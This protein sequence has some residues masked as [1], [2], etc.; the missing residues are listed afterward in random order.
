MDFSNMNETDVREEIVRPLLHDLGYR[1]NAPANI[2]TEVPLRYDYAF[3]GRK[4]ASDP[5]L[6]G[7]ADYICEAT[8]YGRWTVEVK[9]PSEDITRDAIEQ[10]HTYSAHPEIA[11]SY[12]LL[13]NGKEFELYATGQLE[14]PVL[15]FSF[16]QLGDYILLLRNVVGYE[17]LKRL[18]ALT[19]PDQG[20]PL[21]E[22]ISSTMEIVTGEIRYGPHRSSHPL[23][24]SDVMNGV[25]AP[26]VEGLIDRCE[27][28]RLR[29]RVRYRSGFA[30]FDALNRLAGFG[31]LT[32]YC[33]D[34]Y[35]STDRESPSKFQNVQSGRIERGTPIPLIPGMPPYPTP[36]SWSVTAT[37][38]AILFATPNGAQGVLF[39]DYQYE[40]D[41]LSRI[42]PGIPDSL[43]VQ[44]EGTFSMRIGRQ[45]T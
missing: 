44:G 13:T 43:T 11:A 26:I 27:D 1:R 14:K 19:K 16:D 35:I 8:S 10:A 32:F 15:C 7:R 22:N 5:P 33:S 18:H 17:A 4:K 31:D 6:R 3:L 28:G 23:F 38:E 2:R 30:Q 29:A 39:F 40:F 12:F 25:V 9:A 20:K 34:E 21:G 42:Q 45:T 37:T 24:Q 36:V 41:G